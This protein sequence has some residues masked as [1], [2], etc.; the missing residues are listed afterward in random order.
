MSEAEVPLRFAPPDDREE[1]A[2]AEVYGLLALLFHAAPSD[3]LHARLRVAVTEAPAAGAFLERS[4]SEVVAAARRLAPAQV[5][6]EYDALFGGVGKPDVMLHGSWYL[7]GSL[8]EKPLVDLRDTLAAI[9]LER[10]PGVLLTE[11]HLAALCETLRYLIAGA[12]PGSA[13]LGLQRRVFAAHLQ[14]WVEPLVAAIEAH[15]AADF[16]AAVAR[17]LRDFAA[18]E[19][20]AFDMADG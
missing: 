5:G 19:A 4:W 2:R 16:Y 3:D 20:L 10:A 11:D 7:A 1:L 12:G 6:A 18:V 9:G 14:P 15:P 8:N 13:D 17:F